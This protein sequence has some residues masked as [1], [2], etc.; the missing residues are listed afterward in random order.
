M[1]TGFFGDLKYFW[2]TPFFFRKCPSSCGDSLLHY[3]KCEK[4]VGYNQ[5]QVCVV[6]DRS[7][8]TNLAKN[9]ATVQDISNLNP[10]G[11][12]QSIQN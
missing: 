7:L 4:L 2:T 8:S 5:R 10:P 6:S 1:V 12:L 11:V 3:M 9:L